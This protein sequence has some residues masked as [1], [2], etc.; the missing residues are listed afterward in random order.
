MIEYLV[1]GSPFLVRASASN[2]E[3]C[4]A[5]ISRAHPHSDAHTTPGHD[6]PYTHEHQAEVRSPFDPT[7]PRR[8]CSGS[9][10]VAT[11]G[12]WINRRILC[13]CG[14][15]GRLAPGYG[16]QCDFADMDDDWVC[17]FV[18]V[19]VCL[20]LRFSSCSFSSLLSLSRSLVIPP[21]LP[22]ALPRP[23]F[24]PLLSF[25]AVRVCDT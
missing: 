22:R 9:Q 10:A 6:T 21:S 18:F 7:Q 2:F 16:R 19:C 24:P 14:R 17:L 25:C 11:A 5:N 4:P 23:P 13:P 15:E 3:T 12:R 20:C 8:L 1:P